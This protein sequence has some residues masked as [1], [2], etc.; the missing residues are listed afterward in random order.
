MSTGALERVI[1]RAGARRR[2]AA[3][4]HCDLCRETVGEG[5]RHLL[6][7]ETGEALCACTACALLFDRP[8]ASDGHYRL[9]PDRRIRLTGVDPRPLGVPVGLAFFVRQDDGEV[10]AHYPSPA[11]ATRWGIQDAAWDTVVRG[12]PVLA[13]LAPL[14][15]ALLVNTTGE[16]REAWLVP[17]DDCYRLV[18]VVRREWT[19]LTGGDRVGPEIERFFEE[20]GRRHGQDPGR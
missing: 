16:R 13:G 18:A 4:Q 12:C 14:V 5:H 20:L 3:E 17:V 1:R 15:E 9:L 19:G 2:E 10:F 7:T 8:A 11:G 6:D